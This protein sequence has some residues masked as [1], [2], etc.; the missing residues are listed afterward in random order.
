MPWL[1]TEAYGGRRI[2]QEDRELFYK[3]TLRLLRHL[4][5]LA[6]PERWS[7]DLGS[8]VRRTI[9]GDGNFDRSSEADAD[10]F[11]VPQAALG[12]EVRRGDSIG[13]IYSLDGAEQQRICAEADGYLVMLL[14]TPVVRKGDPIYLL[15]SLRQ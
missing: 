2:R 11:F 3:G 9:Y 14:G 10:G 13:T 4:G 5:M 6:N 15:A 8:S 1:Y 7:L 12:A